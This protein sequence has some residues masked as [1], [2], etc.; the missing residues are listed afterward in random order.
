MDGKCSF[1]REMDK[2]AKRSEVVLQF[3]GNKKYGVGLYIYI[4]ISLYIFISAKD[5]SSS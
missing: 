3:T 5:E 2:R 4:F 1:S